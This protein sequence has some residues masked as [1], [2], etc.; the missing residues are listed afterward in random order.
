M[1]R[2]GGSLVIKVL[3]SGATRTLAAALRPHFGKVAWVT[4]KATRRESREVFLVW[5]QAP[6]ARRWGACS[7]ARGQRCLRGVSCSRNVDCC[8]LRGVFL[9]CLRRRAHASGAPAAARAASAA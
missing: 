6:G 5:P 3:E 8:V 7:R 4:P 1:L 2:P 9:V